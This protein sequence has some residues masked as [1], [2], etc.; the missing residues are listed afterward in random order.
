MI[1]C[2]YACVADCSSVVFAAFN[3]EDCFLSCRVGP[4]DSDCDVT[5]SFVPPYF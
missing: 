4:Y 3:H 2:S 5:S 1:Q